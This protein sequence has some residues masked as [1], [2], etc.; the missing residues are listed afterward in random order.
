MF[1]VPVVLGRL[2]AV[3]T[4][5]YCYYY[6]YFLTFSVFLKYIFGVFLFQ[7]QVVSDSVT[8]REL[9]MVS[10]G[11]E[12]IKMKLQGLFLHKIIAFIVWVT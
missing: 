3:S 12:T 10:S 6:L 2:G 7:F 8:M 5:Y 11:K 4:S 9:L 1:L